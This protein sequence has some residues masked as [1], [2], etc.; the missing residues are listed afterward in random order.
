M[1]NLLFVQSFITIAECGSFSKASEKLYIS[2]VSVMNQ[3]NSLENFLGVKLFQRTNH[4]VSLTDSGKSFY[5]DSKK[6]LKMSESAIFNA[7]NIAGNFKQVIRIATSIM[8]PCNQFIESVENNLKE[9]FYSFNVVPFN[10][11]TESLNVMLQSLDDKIDCFISPCG[12]TKILMNY[13]FLPLRNCKCVVAMSRKHFLAKKEI[14]HMED[15]E[16]QSVML[17]KRGNSYVIDQMRDNFIKNYPSVKIIDFDGYY[18]I[19]TFNLCEQ[20]N[21]LMEI[22]DIWTELH[23]SLK[24][25]P[26]DWEYEMPYGVLYSK[27]PSEK[28]KKFID[29]ISKLNFNS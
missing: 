22:P 2:K 11:D 25:V 18:D 14:L 16:N 6:I 17:V 1:L 19:S 7:Q 3:I 29:H 10:E 28:I 27:N 4:G 21:Y 20:Q 9:N 12:S 24:T 15:F 26:V 8:R 13:G 23:P 5:R